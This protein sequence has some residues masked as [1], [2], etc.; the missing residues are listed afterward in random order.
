VSRKRHGGGKRK[1]ALEQDEPFRACIACRTS[2]PK[3]EMVRYARSPDGSV[4]VDIKARLPGR[5]AW[6]CPARGCIERAI[7]K[8]AFARAFDEP[9]LVDAGALLK[10]V[11]D[12]LDEAV[13]GGLGML[14]RQ[15]D[16]VCGR[17]AAL[18][19]HQEKPLA[20]VVVAADLSE[21]S[22]AEVDERFVG[23]TVWHGPPLAVLSHAVGRPETGVIGVVN[24]PQSRRL[25][26]D[27]G[28]RHEH[29]APVV[30][31]AKKRR[32]PAESASDARP[33]SSG[34]A[35]GEPT[36]EPAPK[37]SDAAPDER[38]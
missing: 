12:G 25:G 35:S 8:G 19:A 23:A 4:H 38:G 16:A 21:R 32:G 28:R 3:D 15:G 22:K 2:R 18:R 20:F 34:G 6:T 29:R 24:A 17:E 13:T 5:G 10:A 1:A 7:D 27:L 37:P 26:F 14:R 31:L 11:G 36:E 30:P 33:E 9:C